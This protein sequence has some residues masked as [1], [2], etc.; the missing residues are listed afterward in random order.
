[1]DKKKNPQ[2]VAVTDP[3]GDANSIRSFITPQGYRR[4][5]RDIMSLRRDPAKTPEPKK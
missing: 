1:M 3:Q 2:V 4:R 5:I